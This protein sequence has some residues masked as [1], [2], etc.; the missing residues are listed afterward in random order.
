MS[1]LAGIAAMAVVLMSCLGSSA[2]A[3][4]KIFENPRYKSLALD[5]CRGST[6]G[7]GKPAADVW[8][9]K[10]G[11]ESATKFSM[12]EDVG[13]PTRSVSTNEICDAD[14]C[15]SFAKITCQR[16]D[17]YD[18]EDV[19]DPV[20]YVKPMAGKRRLDWCLDYGTGC[21][22]PAANFYCKAKGHDKAV[23]FKI[24]ENIFMTRLLKTGQKCTD[25]SCDG[26]KFIDCE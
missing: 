3:E 16:A 5:W 2:F 8:C 19:S 20:H 6:V 7:C 13:E 4:S 23:N 1:R 9:T 12:A 21:G 14:Y 26:F 15:D 17:A 11:Y 24:D 18:D 22:K 25:P 10:Q